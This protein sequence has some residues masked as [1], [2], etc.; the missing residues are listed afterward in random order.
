MNQENQTIKSII[1]TKCPKCQEDI[2]VE[3][4]SA[5]PTL[6]STYTPAD[7]EAAK[8]I[9]ISKIKDLAISEDS[10]SGIINWIESDDTVFGMSE[11]DSIVESAKNQNEDIKPN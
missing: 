3:F 1:P 5:I 10:K 8:G 9:A 11:I 6:H 4:H 7:V 2:L